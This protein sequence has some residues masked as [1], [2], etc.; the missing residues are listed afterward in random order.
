MHRAP[1]THIDNPFFRVYVKRRKEGRRLESNFLLQGDKSALPLATYTADRVYIRLSKSSSLRIRHGLHFA[2]GATAGGLARQT[3]ADDQIPPKN[4]TTSMPKRKKK[5][6]Q[7]H[8]NSHDQIFDLTSY[9]L[10]LKI[11]AQLLSSGRCSLR[12]AVVYDTQ[13]HSSC[14]IHPVNGRQSHAALYDTDSSPE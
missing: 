10:G 13:S 8:T 12:R 6:H 3:L 9:R 5:H 11:A 4:D 1:Q 14:S 2:G 7:L